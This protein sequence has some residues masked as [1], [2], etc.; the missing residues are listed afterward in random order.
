MTL[1]KWQD[2]HK[3]LDPVKRVKVK[4]PDGRVG[5]LVNVVRR[6]DGSWTAWVGEEDYDP[7]HGGGTYPVQLDTAR[8]ILD[9]TV[10][11]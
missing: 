5:W 10:I 7:K 1:K 11:A 3:G 4:T 9:W 6:H 8:S 2:E